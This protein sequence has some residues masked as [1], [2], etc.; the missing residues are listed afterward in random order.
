MRCGRTI[1]VAGVAILTLGCQDITGT[2]PVSLTGSWSWLR[3]SDF[4]AYFNL[5]Q[6]GRVVSGDLVSMVGNGVVHT[7]AVTGLVNGHQVLL[8]WSGQ[9][10]TEV[11]H[12]TLQGELSRDGQSIDCAESVNGGQPIAF[13]TLTRTAQ[14]N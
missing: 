10:G 9:V 3:G 6:Q 7:T 2:R 8:Q 12:D 1:I 13:P 14:S 4:F 11:V 5:K